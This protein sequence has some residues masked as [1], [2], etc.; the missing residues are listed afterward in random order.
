MIAESIVLSFAVVVVA[1]LRFAKWCVDRQD[2]MDRPVDVDA[3]KRSIVEKRRILERDRGEWVAC[4][5]RPGNGATDAIAAI[6]QKLLALA[7]E[8]A[9]LARESEVRP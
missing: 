1:S 6:D 8:E 2:K 5:G 9:K 3:M 4:I 7:D